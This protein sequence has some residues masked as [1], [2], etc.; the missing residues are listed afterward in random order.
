MNRRLTIAEQCAQR[1][2]ERAS[3]AL[4]KAEIAQEAFETFVSVEE[5]A[6]LLDIISEELWRDS[7]PTYEMVA[8]EPVVVPPKLTQVRLLALKEIKDITMKKLNKLVGDKR[9]VEMTGANGAGLFANTTREE[10]E[11]DLRRKGADP[12]AILASRALR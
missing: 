10:L 6:L 12:A 4:I 5:T 1:K 8:G 7:Q 9:S 11:A 3:D 2:A